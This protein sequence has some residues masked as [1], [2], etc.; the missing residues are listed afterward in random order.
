LHITLRFFG[1]VTEPVAADL[2]SVLAAVSVPP[3]DIHLEGA[4]AFGELEHMRAVWAGVGA[5]EPLRRLAQKCE[6][7]ARRVGLKAEA[8]TYR[9]HVTLA[10]LKSSPPERIAAW[11]QGHNLLRSPPWLVDRFHLYSSWSGPDG[12]RYDI[13]RT[14]RLT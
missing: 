11:V 14:Y 9:P 5:N 3:F 12:G 8:R 6:T 4:G 1:E 7:A 2:D 10:Y 13:E